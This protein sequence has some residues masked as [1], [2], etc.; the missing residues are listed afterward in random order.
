MAVGGDLWD[1]FE[2]RV[3]TFDREAA[4]LAADR[5][6]AERRHARGGSS[7]AMQEVPA[8]P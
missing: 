5:A 7:D 2:Q 1:G 6:E 3:A 4:R 8:E